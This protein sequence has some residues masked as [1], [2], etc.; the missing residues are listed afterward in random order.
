MEHDWRTCNIEDCN[1]IIMACDECDTPGL[2]DSDQWNLLED[3]RT[4][5]DNCH[6]KEKE[7]KKKII[8]KRFNGVPREVLILAILD[9]EAEVDVGN[10]YIKKLEREKDFLQKTKTKLA[11]KCDKFREF[12]LKQIDEINDLQLRIDE[13]ECERKTLLEDRFERN[14][15]SSTEFVTKRVDGEMQYNTYDCK[16]CLKAGIDHEVKTGVPHGYTDRYSHWGEGIPTTR[17]ECSVCG[18]WCGPWVSADIVGG[19]W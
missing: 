11:K 14:K 10:V 16:H 9:T 4:L 1:E 19:G 15:C 18:R 8:A 3:G 13:L 6:Q 7:E 12:A 17:M 2:Q 5:C